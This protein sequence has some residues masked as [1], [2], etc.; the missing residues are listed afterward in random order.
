[1]PVRPFSELDKARFL[2]FIDGLMSNDVAD[3]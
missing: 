3:Q 2:K 1:M